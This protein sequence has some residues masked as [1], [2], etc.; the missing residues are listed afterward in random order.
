M[1]LGECGRL[2]PRAGYGI[3]DRKEAGSH[4]QMDSKLATTVDPPTGECH[5]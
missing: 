3:G 1:Q 4:K 5:S 2:K